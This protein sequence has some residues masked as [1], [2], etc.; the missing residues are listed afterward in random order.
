MELIFISV[1][2]H[3]EELILPL[4]KWCP[5]WREVEEDSV[6]GELELVLPLLHLHVLTSL[7]I[8]GI[9]SSSCLIVRDDE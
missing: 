5:A 6:E 7:P 2:L 9:E 1:F 3:E 8:E 4:A